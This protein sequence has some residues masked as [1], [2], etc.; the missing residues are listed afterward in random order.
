MIDSIKTNS[1][2][3]RLILKRLNLLRVEDYL[4]SLKPEIQGK[5]VYKA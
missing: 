5:N 3:S 4:C 2:D 1:V